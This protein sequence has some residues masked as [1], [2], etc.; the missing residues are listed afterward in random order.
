MT[1]PVLMPMNSRRRKRPALHITGYTSRWDAVR[2]PRM[3]E[4]YSNVTYPRLPGEGCGCRWFTRG[5]DYLVRLC[6]GHGR[7]PDVHKEMLV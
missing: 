1:A 4:V 6:D 7:V 5:K 3:T 2:G